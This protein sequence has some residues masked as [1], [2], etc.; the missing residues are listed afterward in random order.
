MC[1]VKPNGMAVRFRTLFGRLAKYQL[2]VD[3]SVNSLL[4]VAA[5]L[6]VGIELPLSRFCFCCVSTFF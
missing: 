5:D 2:V 3:V 6:G 4:S 1:A